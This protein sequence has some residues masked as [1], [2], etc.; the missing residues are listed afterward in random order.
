MPFLFL[1]RS[2]SL[3]AQQQQGAAGALAPFASRRGRSSSLR[4]LGPAKAARPVELSRVVVRK[5]GVA[6]VL[7]AGRVRACSDLGAL[8]ARRQRRR[9]AARRGCSPFLKWAGPRTEWQA[10]REARAAAPGLGRW[11]SAPPLPG[12][13]RLASWEVKALRELHESARRNFIAA[14]VEKTLKARPDLVA[15]AAADPRWAESEKN[16]A[17]VYGE[18]YGDLSADDREWLVGSVEFGLAVA[19]EE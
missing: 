19:E 3:P 9:A 14:E 11:G 16:C 12:P 18:G 2:K 5:G 4:L 7:R 1:R 13:P 8:W 10:W 15:E 17:R 6:R